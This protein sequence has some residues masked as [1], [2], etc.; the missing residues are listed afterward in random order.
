MEVH[1]SSA[2]SYRDEARTQTA[3]TASAAL[4]L[5]APGRYKL[6]AIVESGESFRLSGLKARA[7]DSMSEMRSSLDHILVVSVCC[8]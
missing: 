1:P 5:A 3:Q 4:K 2:G 7:R 8:E 6:C